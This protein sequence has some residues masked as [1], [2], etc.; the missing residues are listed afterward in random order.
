VLVMRVTDN[1]AYFT[2]ASGVRSR[3]ERAQK[4]EN[5]ACVQRF[6]DPCGHVQTVCSDSVEESTSNIR[7][8]AR[9]ERRPDG[10]VTRELQSNDRVR[11]KSDGNLHGRTF[12]HIVVDDIYRLADRPHTGSCPVG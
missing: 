2:Y 5:G 11:L 10:E 12:H 3:P 7:T 1:R 9:Y 6:D 8:F 4:T